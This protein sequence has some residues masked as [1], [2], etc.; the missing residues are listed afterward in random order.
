MSGQRVLLL[1]SSGPRSIT[2]AR[3]RIDHH[4]FILL[5]QRRSLRHSTVCFKENNNKDKASLGR[6]AG[7]E[8]LLKG[9]S[10]KKI[11]KTNWSRPADFTPSSSSPKKQQQKKK[12][13]RDPAPPPP[14]AGQRRVPPASRDWTR[15]T[16]DDLAATAEDITEDGL[17]RRAPKKLSHGKEKRPIDKPVRSKKEDE[18]LA[19]KLRQEEQALQHLAEKKAKK[20]QQQEEAV[21]MR[22]VY[23]P[24]VIN[25]ANLARVLGVRLG[26]VNG[27]KET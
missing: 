3:R 14:A 8:A 2:V 17:G 26:K 25:V 1:C 20:K 5:S 15:P 23:I 27:E 10:N 11:T 6:I 22:D 9:G 4:P 24:Q 7:L 18:E 21:Q 16:A 19:A 13:A 12:P